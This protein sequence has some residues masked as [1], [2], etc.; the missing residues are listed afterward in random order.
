[1]NFKEKINKEH[2]VEFDDGTQVKM[3]EEAGVYMAA[4]I[5]AQLR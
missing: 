5:A 1:M 4:H 3:S 2:L